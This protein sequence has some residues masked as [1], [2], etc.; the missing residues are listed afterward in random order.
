MVGYMVEQPVDWLLL[1]AVGCVA[2]GFS[3]C[4]YV[5]LNSFDQ[6]RS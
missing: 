6:N 4:S 5:K 2:V 3:W 1:A